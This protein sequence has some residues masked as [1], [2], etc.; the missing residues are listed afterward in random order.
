MSI[1]PAD[2]PLWL[3]AVIVIN[4]VALMINLLFFSAYLGLAHWSQHFLVLISHTSLPVGSARLESDVR[5]I[6]GVALEERLKLNTT[7]IIAMIDEN[8]VSSNAAFKNLRAT[9]KRLFPD[10]NFINVKPK[11]TDIP[12]PRSF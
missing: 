11:Q 7:A 4:L 6:L 8:I 10:R 12:A 9:L 1:K 5:K 3:R 2:Y